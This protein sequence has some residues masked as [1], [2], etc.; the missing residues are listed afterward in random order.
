[1]LGR[2]FVSAII[3]QTFKLSTN[4][5]ENEEKQ[6]LVGWAP[7][8]HDMFSNPRFPYTLRGI[9]SIVNFKI[10]IHYILIWKITMDNTRKKI[11]ISLMTIR[12]YSNKKN[13]KELEQYDKKWFDTI[14]VDKKRTK[15]SQNRT[16]RIF[17]IDVWLRW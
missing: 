12:Y 2:F 17:G 13:V 7:S 8:S 5:V 11:N 10:I 15:C 3:L 4:K 14:L 1:M 6:R 16:N 9:Y